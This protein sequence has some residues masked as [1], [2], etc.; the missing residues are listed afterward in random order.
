M[1]ISLARRGQTY[2]LVVKFEK[3]IG[4]VLTFGYCDPFFGL[5]YDI[6]GAASQSGI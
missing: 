4:K 5:W 2:S 1:K 3:I 6:G